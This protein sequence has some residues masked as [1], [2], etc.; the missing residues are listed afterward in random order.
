VSEGDGVRQ[1]Q[2][3]G[4]VGDTGAAGGARLYFEVR[5]MGKAV[6]PLG[7]LRPRG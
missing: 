4:T 1:G 3:L 2:S 7:W 5:H 6:Y